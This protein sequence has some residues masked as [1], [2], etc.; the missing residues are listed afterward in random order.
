MYADSTGEYAVCLN[1]DAGTELWRVRTGGYY[2]EGQGGDG[3]R[4]TPTVD[5]DIV[6]VLGAEGSLHALEAASG[7]KLWKINLVEEFG[8]KVPKWGFSTSPLI[9]GDL[10]L[11]EV[12]GVDGSFI[13]DMVIAR[14]T[15]ATAV[16]LDK[17]TG[18]PAWTALDDKMSYS[19]PIAY[20]LEGSRQIAFSNSYALVGLSPAD[21]SE[22]WRYP[23]KTRWD[24]TA[25]TPVF[26]PPNR[27]FTSGGSSGALV[28][29]GRNTVEELWKNGEMRNHFG[30]SIH[31]QGYLYGF[32]NSILKCVDVESGEQRWKA[33]GYSKGTLIAADGHLILLGE[34]GNLGLAVATPEGF[35]ENA[36]VPLMTNRCWTM[37]S[38]SDGRLYVRNETEI[39]AV[40]LRPTSPRT[41]SF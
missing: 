41:D 6:Y 35:V 4:S 16:A 2:R 10:L 7:R 24:V 38:L 17:S 28:R 27:L 11:L 12:G 32:D 37:P 39:V 9:E 18:R 33:R 20:N 22:L 14:T 25:A 1:V 3:P 31:Y 15:Q 34:K 30:T 19:S 36:N 29:A 5:G 21:G 40:D 8:G 26:I 13:V 23:F